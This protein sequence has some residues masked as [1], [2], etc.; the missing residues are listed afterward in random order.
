MA[1][2]QIKKIAAITGKTLCG[3]FALLCLLF[4]AVPLVLYGHFNHGNLA[5]LCYAFLLGAVLFI[6][7]NR[8]S[9]ALLPKLIFWIR[10]VL[11]ALLAVC[12]LVGAVI[13]CFMVKYAFFHEPPAADTD[14]SGGTAIV[15]GCQVYGETPSVSLRGRLDA[16]YE[17]LAS[18]EGSKAIVAG[19]Q[20]EDETVP[21]AYVMKKYLVSRG[22]AE[23]RIL[24]E[25]RSES[26]EENIRF[27]GEIIEENGLPET[28]YI[29]TD[30]YH[31][32]RAFLFA[33]ENGYRA[34][35]ISSDLYWPLLGEYWVREILGVLHMKLTPNWNL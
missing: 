10:L 4:G 34:Y 35:N 23:E 30:A 19:G 25:D 12:F 6:R 29:I 27:S 17:Y 24:M 14:G 9:E 7:G 18:H 3:A 28:M 20:G 2:S 26:T 22:I 31:S 32:Y 5:L 21:E 1:F 16:A 33:E 13:S 11:S 8:R 15:L